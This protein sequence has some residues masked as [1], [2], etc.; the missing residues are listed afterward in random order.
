VL[1]DSG[2]LA[3]AQL[4]LGLASM[5]KPNCFSAGEISAISSPHRAAIL[6]HHGLSDRPLSPQALS[7][8]SGIPE[9]TVIRET[10][11][12]VDLGF[13]TR[14]DASDCTV[15]NVEKVQQFLQLLS[16]VSIRNL[17]SSSETR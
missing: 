4:K 1:L 6:H 11:I 5:P 7:Q 8:A 9:F 16:P 3:R 10:R 14:D 2:V 17:A 15:M 12:L 13:L